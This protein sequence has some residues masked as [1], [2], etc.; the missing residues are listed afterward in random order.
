MT[1]ETKRVAREPSD[2]EL[3]RLVNKHFDVLG[4]LSRTVW[5]DSIDIE[6]PSFALRQ[7]VK[8]LLATYAAPAAV[9]SDRERRLHEVLRKHCI[10]HCAT[11]DDPKWY[12]WQC[13]A[14]WPGP[15]VCDERHAP[16]CLAAPL[17]G[18]PL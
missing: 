3:M 7:F 15:D 12:C 16:G 1:D 9:P 4:P 17:P 14:E 10:G 13:D 18:E 6:E 11:P 2:D 8:E 5:K